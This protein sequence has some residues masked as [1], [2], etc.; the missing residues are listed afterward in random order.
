MNIKQRITNL[1][2]VQKA[3][4]LRKLKEKEIHPP[5]R[6]SS[7][8]I[9]PSEKKDYYPVSASQR[10]MYIINN[11]IHYTMRLPYLVDVEGE[12]DRHQL[13][14]VFRRLIARHESLRT[15][16]HLVGGEPVQRVHNRVEFTLE[17]HDV[18]EKSVEIDENGENPEVIRSTLTPIL[19]GFDLSEPPLLRVGLIKLSQGKYLFVVNIHHIISDGV[20]MGIM[21]REFA[22]LYRGET[23]PD[24]KIQYKDYAQWENRRTDAGEYKKKERYWLETFSSDPPPLD[25]PTDAPRPAVQ[26]FEGSR[27]HFEIEGE[28]YRGLKE[29]ALKQNASI[30]M[31]LLAVLNTQLHRYTGREDI[32]VGSITAGRERWETEALIGV[33][34]NAVALRNSPKP[35][36]TFAEFLKELKKNTLRAFENQSY[37]FGDLLD[38]VVTK[39]DL[40]RN[41]LF[42]VMLIFQSVDM[43]SRSQLDRLQLQLD[44]YRYETIHHAQQD[45]TVW[46]A[47]QGERVRV[48]LEYATAL[49]KQETIER[50]ASHFITLLRSAT[51]TPDHS[52]HELELIPPAEKQKILEQFNDTETGLTAKN[53]LHH[54]F[55]QQ[56]NRTPDYIAVTAPPGV[57]TRFIASAPSVS[58]TYRRLNQ[59]SNRLAYILTERGVGPETVVALKMPRSIDMFVAILGILKAGGA[60]LPIDPDT[61]AER[62]EYILKDSNAGI[63]IETS[64]ARDTG[65]NVENKKSYPHVLNFE[66]L[67]LEIV[68][69]F[70]S[71]A[72]E[73]PSTL[74]YIIYTS[75]STGR[76]KGVMIEHRNLVTYLEAFQREIP[77]YPEDTVLQQA[78]YTF[79]TFG[80]EVYPALLNGATL[81]V[82]PVETVKDTT[83]LA[84]FIRK[85]QVTVVDGSPLLLNQLNQLQKTGFKSSIRLYISGGDE[86]KAEY[87]DELVKTAEVYNT[88]GPTEG[89]ICAT[90]YRCS[91]G[92]PS[93]WRQTVPIG[94][95]IADCRATILSPENRIQPVGIPG[96]LCITGPG[97]ARGYLNRPELTA[98]KFHF[99]HST[100]NSTNSGKFYPSYRT[101]D[102]VRWQPDGNIQFLGRID[103]QV[104]IRGYRIELKEIEHRLMEN[105]FIKEAVVLGIDNGHQYLC[106]YIVPVE[107]KKQTVTIPLLREHLTQR[108][109]EYM[110][111]AHFVEIDDVPVTTNG[112]IDEK[113]LREIGIIGNIQSGTTYESPANEIEEKLAAIWSTVLK[114]DRI[115][116]NDN[117]FDHGGQ[118]ILAMRAL[119][120]ARETF[121]VKIPLLTFFQH[122]TIRAIAEI[123]ANAS[124]DRKNTDAV[125]S[126]NSG[127]N[128]LIQPFDLEKAPLLRTTVVQLE[129][130][131]YFFFIDMHHI[132]T[133][134]ISLDIVAGEFA[135]LYGGDEPE[136]LPIRYADYA[137]WQEN[138]FNGKLFKQQEQYWLEVFKGEPPRLNLPPDYPRSASTRN[139]S[140][141]IQRKIDPELLRQLKKTA[142]QQEVTLYMILLA[143]YTVVLA[144]H[145]GQ[146]DIVV[147]TPVSGRN[148]ANLNRLVGMFVNTLA[149]RLKPLKKLTFEEYL[150]N[151]K[152][153]TLQALKNQDYPF[154]MLVEK[155]DLSGKTDGNPLFDTMFTLLQPFEDQLEVDVPQ[156]GTTNHITFTPYDI[157]YRGAQFDLVFNAAL[158]DRTLRFNFLYNI[159]LFREE[160]IRRMTEDYIEILTT[161]ASAM[162]QGIDELCGSPQSFPATPTAQ[163][164]LESS[165]ETEE[166]PIPLTDL[167]K[168]KIMEIVND[169]RMEYPEDMTLH[170]LFERQA[171]ATPHRTAVICQNRQLTYS[172]LNR[173]ADLVAWILRERGFIYD[174]IV[175]L[176][177]E[178]SMEMMVGILGIL[179]A[180]GGYLP[181]NIKQ[182]E[183][184]IRYLIRD[185]A[186]S[187][188]LTQRSLNAPY[189]SETAGEVIE[190]DQ[191]ETT[192]EYT[193]FS[194]KPYKS[195]VPVTPE[196]KSYIIYTSGSTGRPKGV[197]VDH[198]AVVN[199]LVW[200]QKKYPLSPT[201]TVLQ[202]TVFVFDVSVIEL[203]GWYM[204][205][206]RLCFLEPGAD[207]DLQKILDTIERFQITAVSYTPT[208][209]QTFYQSIGRENVGKLSS[210][211]WIFSAG[212]QLPSGLVEKWKDFGL[213]ASLENLYGPTEAAVYASWYTCSR[214]STPKPVPIGKPLGNTRL[215][216]MDPEH[217]AV[218]PGEVGE[219]VLAGGGLAKGYLNRPELTAEKFLPDPYVQGDRMYLTGD[220]ARLLMQEDNGDMVYL[221]R[222]DNQVKIRG[223]RIELGEI[224]AV[225][226][227]HPAIRKAAVTAKEDHQGVMYLAA[228]LQSRTKISLKA[229]RTHLLEHLPVY[230]LPSYFY[231]V[232]R[233]PMTAS[234]KLDRKS[235]DR[236]GVLMEA[237]NQYVPPGTELERQ[238]AHRWADVLNME[239]IGIDHNF[240]EMGGDSL[241]GNLLLTII[242]NRYGSN[243]QINDLFEAPTIR[244]MTRLLTDSDS[245]DQTGLAR[246][247]N[248]DFYPATSA[249]K[250][251]YILQQLHK[252]DTSYN[253]SLG[254]TVEGDLDKK[255]LKDTVEK[256]VQR[257]DSLRTA[258]R[259]QDGTIVQEIKSNPEIDIKFV[260][261]RHRDSRGLDLNENTII[262][263]IINRG[264]PE[265]THQPSNIE[266]NLLSGVKLKKARRKRKTF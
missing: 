230:M 163:L 49:F 170:G 126:A 80:E 32:V 133:D 154:E 157:E 26:R 97:V 219:L 223:I 229:L 46:A 173:R 238:L 140:K 197:V 94:S 136:P 181:L 16:F 233:M 236:Y 24:M 182:P 183:E 190:L 146:Q 120:E 50:F 165:K 244:Q 18:S 130:R 122:G 8:S 213:T 139:E 15:S 222:M 221:G 184:Q 175:G 71:R 3:I 200:M 48:D 118:S 67:D 57:G 131:R 81:A 77:V 199:R 123:I 196:N 115:G 129:D 166:Q 132:V 231:T 134:G 192:K 14:M 234:G 144:K 20:S 260:D 186:I 160:T 138:H 264:I 257:H 147:G 62:V 228:Y 82:P 25:I 84:E 206:A 51:S 85:Q 121:N 167:Q 201:D 164:G 107:E 58:I 247:E 68:S 45:I 262:D 12:L 263:Q 52:L 64:D 227:K 38:K 189:L 217:R 226:L 243:L 104:K 19:N 169:S 44:R 218:P 242:N 168:E 6:T 143:V 13:E 232:D 178:P 78:S 220:Y 88:Y 179:K 9:E 11:F 240:L 96:E 75:G 187:I 202:K 27:V 248:R 135:S 106:A 4:L 193:K 150:E 21:A 251:L 28:D 95:P 207:T 93:D 185:A 33:F 158:T 34:I 209:L 69:N 177:V 87:I 79:D 156:D 92:A 245:N 125:S 224:E 116:V 37:P 266:D 89:T 110:I 161:V 261:Y 171:E 41:P 252:D 235:L 99:P 151:V 117:F 43:R 76:P 83:L 214:E 111:P 109:P 90:H 47:E 176:M 180:G 98:E 137:V 204:G 53:P 172:Q 60:Y 39:K 22:R 205:G 36:N 127:S 100:K 159:H 249:Q 198:R 105:E 124:D 225:I 259:M 255:R 66:Y 101:G 35:G 55:Q 174:T 86:L 42:D 195:D 61:P 211:K 91:G 108:L 29:L 210:L 153:H 128:G 65:K 239:R 152:N 188:L 10:R 155:L 148:H 119:E 253:F 59:K 208:V 72:S 102:L 241:K 145:T 31:V 149:L 142:A 194:H 17:F 56:V 250:R 212:E 246:M 23:L 237:D 141:R 162:T 30:Y 63:L 2:P 203:L 254:M 103:R 114:K 54:I 265:E 70:E 1:T 74:C 113:K 256:L 112:K 258:F 73:T 215:Y 191:L 216:V 7:P 5:G 40:S